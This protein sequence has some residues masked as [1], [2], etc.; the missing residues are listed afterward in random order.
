M[1]DNSSFVGLKRFA[2][3]SMNRTL[4]PNSADFETYLDL[5]ERYANK[6]N[7]LLNERFNIVDFTTSDNKLQKTMHCITE[8]GY[9]DLTMQKNAMTGHNRLK[10]SILEN[11]RLTTKSF[12]YTTFAMYTKLLQNLLTDAPK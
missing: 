3:E 1:N 8:G 6:T 5:T 10:M 2:L 7:D 12:E 9:V 11:G 4:S